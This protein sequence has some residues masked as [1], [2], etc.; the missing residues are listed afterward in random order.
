MALEILFMAGIISIEWKTIPIY[1]EGAV[2][3]AWWGTK[4]K[5]RN[6]QQLQGV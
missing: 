2:G 1:E 5:L 4:E 6:L 3:K